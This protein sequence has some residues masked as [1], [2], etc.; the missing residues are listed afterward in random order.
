M[1][2]YY[3]R[4]HLVPQLSVEEKIKTIRRGLNSAATVDS[5]QYKFKFFEVDYVSF[6]DDIYLVGSLV[7]YEPQ[8]FEERADEEEELIKK[9]PV[10]DKVVARARFVLHPATSLIIHQENAALY[11]KVI[12][13]RTFE[14]LFSLNN[15]NDCTIGISPVLNE[16]SFIDSVKKFTEIKRVTIE[17]VPSNPHFGRW[18]NI[19]KKIKERNLTTYKETQENKRKGGSIIIDSETEDKFYMAEDGYGDSEVTGIING[20]TDTIS[21]K[22]KNQQMKTSIP[23]SIVSNEELVSKLFDTINLILQRVKN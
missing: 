15:N 20:I 11:N 10:S 23:Q 5:N 22:R 3:S 18:E 1:L 2:Y 21:T 12:F 7:K 9:V 16:Y 6:K 13:Y 17:L 14:Q 8:G 19:D 4:F